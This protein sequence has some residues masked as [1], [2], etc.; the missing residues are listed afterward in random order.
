MENTLDHFEEQNHLTDKDILT[1]IW[2]APRSIFKYIN[3]S[4]Y[5]KYT[6]IFLFLSGVSSAFDRANMKNLGDEMSLFAIIGL[7][8]IL[9]GLFGWINF[10]LY[11]AL[12]SWTGKWLNGQ[13]NTNSILR[14][15][16]YAMLPLILSLILLI[17]QLL[18]FGNEIF[19]EA[20]ELYSDGWI[21][22]III[23]TF[24]LFDLLLGAWS[25]ILL[26]IGISEVQKLSIGKSII[27]LLLPVSIILIP[28]LLFDL[29][30][31]FFN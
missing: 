9:G 23:Y 26:I 30:K 3:D 17:P 6:Y 8:T 24:F 21:S 10:Y 1:K 11:A 7:C 25:I 29:I 4:K 14:I 15:I 18:I 20:G 31:F 27:N 12:C 2:T 28:I 19:K 5:D 16:S 13:G 22:K